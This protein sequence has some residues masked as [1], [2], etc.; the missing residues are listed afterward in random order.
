LTVEQAFFRSFDHIIR[1]QLDLVWHRVGQK[2]KVLIG[3]LTMLRKLLTYLVSYDCVTFHSFLETIL[4]S[5]TP[6]STLNQEQQS[7]W[8]FMDSGNTIFSVAKRKDKETDKLWHPP[9]IVPVLEEL[10]KWGLLA[11]IVNEIE[12]EI[13]S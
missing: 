5:Q 13:E 2:T 4:A 1:Q 3:D 10:P 6:S 9:G 12:L 8:I 11:E 7:P